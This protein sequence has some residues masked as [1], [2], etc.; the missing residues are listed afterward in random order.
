MSQP[1]DPA[2]SQAA[3]DELPGAI[4]RSPDPRRIRDRR[5]RLHGWRRRVYDY[6]VVP[7][8]VPAE[9]NEPLQVLIEKL[10]TDNSTAAATTLAE[11]QAIFDEAAGRIESA[12]RRA[13]TLQGTVAIAAS[14]VVAFAG[15]L[16]DPAK[17]ADRGWRIALLIVLA[18]FLGSLIGCAWRALAVTGRMFEFEQPGPERIHLRAKSKGT[19]AQTFRSAELL[20]A[21]GVASEIGAVKVGLLRSAAWWLR[22]ALTWLAL[23][24]VG[25]CI[26]VAVGDHSRQSSA[27]QPRPTTTSTGAS[28]AT[29]AP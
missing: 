2:A 29:K 21:A 13:T 27:P 10:S 9:F 28:H 12:E 20:R 4:D 1:Q 23:L 14:L 25:L 6:L 22:L 7:A 19:L 5:E 15:F 24:V 26:Y 18:A 8:E 16:L 3:N 11:A 17:I